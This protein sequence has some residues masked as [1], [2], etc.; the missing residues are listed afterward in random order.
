MTSYVTM[1]P[2]VAKDLAERKLL[3]IE[4]ARDR[5]RQRFVEGEIK[6]QNSSWFRRLFRMRPIMPLD[7]IQQEQ[8]KN[9][10]DSELWMIDNWNYGRSEEL[11]Q[12]ILSS[13]KNGK[14]IVLA[15]HDAERLHE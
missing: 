14:E 3:R 8:S 10:W 12:Q 7:I 11:C 5:D 4:Q 2:E 1:N 13:V 9:N 6:R 15:L